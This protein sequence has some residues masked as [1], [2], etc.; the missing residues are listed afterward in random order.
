M[1]DKKN[2]KKDKWDGH[3]DLLLL[4]LDP[5]WG[6]FCISDRK[7]ILIIYGYTHG[8]SWAT[9]LKLTR[10]FYFLAI[11][12]RLLGVHKCETSNFLPGGAAGF[13]MEKA[14]Q[15]SAKLDG[16][17]CMNCDSCSRIDHVKNSSNAIPIAI[18]GCIQSCCNYCRFCSPRF[19]AVFA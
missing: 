12:G 15:I 1:N 9:L 2:D 5:I 10:A 13:T 3:P 4:K 11:E 17:R 8:Q 14:R 7:L 19:L 6:Y 18:G 16:F